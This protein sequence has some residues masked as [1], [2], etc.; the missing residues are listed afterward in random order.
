M[1]RNGPF[2]VDYSLINNLMHYYYILDIY[3]EHGG[4]PKLLVH[5]L[6]NTSIE[7]S[8]VFRK[9]ATRVRT[10]PNVNRQSITTSLHL[11]IKV[12]SSSD[13]LGISRLL[14]YY[15]HYGEIS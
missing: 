12:Q 7:V 10:N 2:P 14:M 15:L 3:L 13:L 9:S 8:P 11:E 1:T 4:P 5:P 6:L